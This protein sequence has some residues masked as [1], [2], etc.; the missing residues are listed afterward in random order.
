MIKDK[1]II[2]DFLR[3]IYNP[4][5]DIFVKD[6]MVVLDRLRI[7]NTLILYTSREGDKNRKSLLERIGLNEAFDEICLVEKKDRKTMKLIAD[8]YGKK[9]REVIVIGDRIK[10]EI[11]IGNKNNFQT[12]WFKN[13]KYSKKGAESSIE[14]PDFLIDNLEELLK[15]SL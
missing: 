8:K 3:T 10:S 11:L 13:G 12:I 1:L 5:K 6:A 14:E 7:G 15:L 2:F 9:N 4:D